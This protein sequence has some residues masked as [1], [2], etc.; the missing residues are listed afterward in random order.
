MSKQG[1]TTVSITYAIRDSLKEAAQ[2]TGATQSR[3]FWQAWTEYL[4]NHPE[5]T[6]TRPALRV[7]TP[8]PP[9]MKPSAEG[10]SLA[11]WDALKEK[12][13]IPMEMPYPSGRTPAEA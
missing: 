13:I 7:R 10:I 8:K 9:K 11:T 12:G 3:L 5:I 2:S 1:F 4:T 6:A